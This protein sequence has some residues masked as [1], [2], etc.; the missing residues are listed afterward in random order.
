MDVLQIEALS[1]ALRDPATLQLYRARLTAFTSGAGISSTSSADVR[2][3]LTEAGNRL[4]D[5]L[6]SSDST[7]VHYPSV[8]PTIHT[9][10]TY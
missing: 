1:T 8:R 2:R 9:F 6:G 10:L 7:Q 4:E 3:L 5:L